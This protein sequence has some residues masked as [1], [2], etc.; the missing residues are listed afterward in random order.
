MCVF[1]SL[2]S[3]PH[4]DETSTFARQYDSP[5]LNWKPTSVTDSC[6]VEGVKLRI[7]EPL[8]KLPHPC[9]LLADFQIVKCTVTNKA[10][11]ATIGG[12]SGP[13]H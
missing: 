8:N 10:G 6:P 11:A 4:K 1:P 9:E 5:A 2:R 13:Y 3:P 7:A 12:V